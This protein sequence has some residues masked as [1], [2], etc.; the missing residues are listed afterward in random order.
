MPCARLESDPAFRAEF[1]RLALSGMQPAEM[2]AALKISR[3]T[4]YVVARRIGLV[5]RHRKGWAPGPAVVP[6]ES[7]A[8]RA[9]AEVRDY[10]GVRDHAMALRSDDPRYP[11][12][13]RDWIVAERAVRPLLDVAG[14]VV[15]GRRV[16]V[17]C[18]GDVCVA[19]HRPPRKHAAGPR[20]LR[21]ASVDRSATIGGQS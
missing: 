13:V 19:I 20:M 14:V 18:I 11:H 9:D 4:V 16:S 12:A 17:D 5:V 7:S 21:V 1:A 8:D 10:L 6:T 2:A 3:C 15:D